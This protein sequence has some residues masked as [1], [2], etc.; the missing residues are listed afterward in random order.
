M[1]PSFPAAAARRRSGGTGKARRGGKAPADERAFFDPEQCGFSA[2]IARLDELAKG[3][4]PSA[5]KRP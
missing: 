1:P 4:D 3:E 2:L 5:Q